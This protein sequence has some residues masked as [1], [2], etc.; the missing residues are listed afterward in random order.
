MAVSILAVSCGNKATIKGTVEGL[1]DA[2]VVVRMLDINKYKVLDTLKT[3]NQGRFSYKLDVAKGNPEFVYVF[4]G[5]NKLASLLLAAGDKVSFKADTLGNC[6]VEGSEESEKL[7]QTEIDFAVFGRKMDAISDRLIAETDK[8]EISKIKQEL[9]STYID[10]YR[11]R[12]KYV[13]ENPFSLT[14]VPVL[15]Q[16]VSEGLPVFAQ[17]ADAIHFKSACDSLEQV[18]P[19]SKYVKSL[20]KEANR[21]IQILELNA[22]VKDADEVGF[23]DIKLPDVTGASRNLSDVSSEIVMLYFW[24]SSDSDQKMFNQDI[25]KPIY[26][27]YHKRGLDIYAV[28]LDVDKANWASVVKNQ[29]LDWINVCDIRGVTSNYVGLYN[30]QSLPSSFFIRKGEL[31]MTEEALTDAASLKKFLNKYI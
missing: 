25:I 15:Y 7:L 26:E 8:S 18:Y 10:Y 5:E 21:R 19:E 14:V 4:Y 9:T 31:L 24:D 6:Q 16:Q 17:Q 2:D 30:L 27:E 13:M 20:R 3:D 1:A 22:R 11:S 28:S 29:G 23:P 12:V